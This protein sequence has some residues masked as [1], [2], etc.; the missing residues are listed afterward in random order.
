MSTRAFIGVTSPDR[1]VKYVVCDYDGYPSWAGAYLLK[2]YNTRP[3]AEGLIAMGRI[4][5]IEP[6]I[7]Q[8]TFHRRDLAKPDLE[9]IT[10]Y[11]FADSALAYQVQRDN[12]TKTA[13]GIEDYI[14]R[15]KN[16]DAAFAYLYTD[17]GW[18]A[19]QVTYLYQ[20]SPFETLEQT[21]KSIPAEP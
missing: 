13:D 12:R 19:A 20:P 14:Y 3:K 5:N 16:S 6:S 15:A 9:T 11:H 7:D 10:R 8:S 4:R 2:H 17:N 21:L 18:L 1:T